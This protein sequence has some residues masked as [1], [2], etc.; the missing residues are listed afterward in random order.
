MLTLIDK[1]YRAIPERDAM[2]RHGPYTSFCFSLGI[3][4]FWKVVVSLVCLVKQSPR[5]R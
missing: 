3:G 4:I 5:L 1:R 2:G